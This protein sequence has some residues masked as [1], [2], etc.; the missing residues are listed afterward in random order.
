MRP[1]IPQLARSLAIALLVV[2]ATAC[3]STRSGSAKPVKSRTSESPDLR[4]FETA[5]VVPFPCATQQSTDPK[6]GENFAA[7]IAARL[8]NDFGPLFREVRL[9]QPGTQA[10]E[11]VIR[12]AI[13]KYIPGNPAA[14]MMLIG[15]G[16][17]HFEA[18]VR[19]VDGES[20]A[21]LFSAPI[22]K[23]WAWGG[24]MGAAKD[25]DRMMAE[26]AASVA[27]TIAQGKGWEPERKP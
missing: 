15:L 13:T 14:R 3:S 17:A 23:L 5:T 18:D 7:D 2:S 25:I 19:L 11:L 12:G 16:S 20:G 22:D 27:A 26:S 10:N 4:R 21:E 8:R 1:L 9:G 24:L 6:V